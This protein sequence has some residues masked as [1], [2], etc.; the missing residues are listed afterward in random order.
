MSSIHYF[1]RYSQPENVATNNT[2]LLFS[3]L[4]QQS[5]IK[6][7][8]FLNDLLDD[9]DI[10]GGILFYQQ[11]KAQGS[12]PDGSLSQV[13]FKVVIET[14]LH[15]H[16]SLPQLT[17]HLKD[18]SKEQY[19]VLLSLSPKH[20][21][22]D[23]IRKIESAVNEHNLSNNTAIKYLHTT[24]QEIVTK[25]K[26]NIEDYDYELNDIVDDYE[27]YCINDELIRDDDARMRVVTCGWTLDENFKY[28]LYY[29][30]ADRG[31]TDHTY[32]G[33]YANKAVR[34]I[35]KLENII[36]ADLLP[37]GKLKIIDST[38]EI[39]A[40]QEQNIIDI[41]PITKA[42]HGWDI[43]TGHKFFCVE[44]FCPTT[45]RKVTKYPLQGT[46]FFNLKDRLN[47]NP[48]PSTEEIAERLNT[49]D[50]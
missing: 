28:S 14:K 50:W 39:T 20:P 33:I 13:S 17:E 3:R 4:Y 5:P 49:I 22:N 32:L 26:A 10:E 1:Q 16:F 18:F 7:K 45:F 41:I 36:T 25:F 29:D 46:K 34:G 19:Q 37:S 42:K 43:A 23:L 47:L 31:Y 35:G 9:R 8:A 11:K 38:S 21:D 2:L 30:P 12:I 6:F 44:K 27:A 24:F 48:L 40:R 15:K